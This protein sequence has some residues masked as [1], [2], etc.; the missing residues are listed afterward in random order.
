MRRLQA[1]SQR[2]TDQGISRV[3]AYE[4]KVYVRTSGKQTRIQ[5]EGIFERVL[6]VRINM[7]TRSTQTKY[8]NPH[9]LCKRKPVCNYLGL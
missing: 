8:D 4:Q 6:N 5:G 3:T 9:D 7:R 2:Q 1:K